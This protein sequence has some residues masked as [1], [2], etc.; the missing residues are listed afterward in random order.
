MDRRAMMMSENRP[1]QPSAR[2]LKPVRLT[3]LLS[4]I[5]R[6]LHR[7]ST[8]VRTAAAVAGNI[9]G[10]GST[11]RDDGNTQL[12]RRRLAWRHA[13]DDT[14]TPPFALTVLGDVHS[15]ALRACVDTRT[16]CQS[17]QIVRMSND[18][19]VFFFQIYAGSMQTDSSIH[20]VLR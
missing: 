7:A 1:T 13:A 20:C 12:G 2:R 4:T 8:S 18:M 3:S 19:M 16:R 15:S 17:V 14:M 11:W 9:Q 6:R 10:R 5:I